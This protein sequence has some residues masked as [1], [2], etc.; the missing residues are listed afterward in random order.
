MY[1]VALLTIPGSQKQP[2][3][4]STEQQ[5]KKKWYI[6]TTEYYSAIKR[7]KI[8]PFAEMWIYLETYTKG[9]KSDSEKQVS[10]ITASV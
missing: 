8:G 4:L 3:C 2:K 9:S 10:F 1:T 7:K 6:L 5:I